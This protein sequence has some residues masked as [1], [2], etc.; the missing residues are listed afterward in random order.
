ML[1][2]PFVTEQINDED[3]IKLAINH[4]N[5]KVAAALTSVQF[6]TKGR[7]IRF[8]RMVLQNSYGSE[9]IKLRSQL[10]I[11]VYD[12]ASFNT[13][14]DESCLTPLIGERELGAG[15]MNLWHYRLIIID[16]DKIRVD[17]T[18]ASVSDSFY[19]GI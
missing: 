3:G 15:N 2:K 6:V 7:Q 9:H 18:Q 5:N 16:S 12:G 19:D 14:S 11:V 8:A 13:H 4:L 17:D 10:T 1:P